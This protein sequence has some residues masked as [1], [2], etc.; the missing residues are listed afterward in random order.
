MFE[1]DP[2]APRQRL[3]N[4]LTAMHGTGHMRPLLCEFVARGLLPEGTDAGSD[5]WGHARGA[6][7]GARARRRRRRLGRRRP[8][9]DCVHMSATVVTPLNI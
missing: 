4:L 6:G 8:S 1:G 9:G 5:E 3:L 2:R 7:G